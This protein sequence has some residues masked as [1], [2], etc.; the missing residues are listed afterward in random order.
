MPIIEKPNASIIGPPPK[1]AIRTPNVPKTAIH[2][3]RLMRSSELGATS[4]STARNGTAVI[5]SMRK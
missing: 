5:V 2:A 3:E 1:E 4:G